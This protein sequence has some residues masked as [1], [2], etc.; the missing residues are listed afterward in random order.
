MLTFR[1]FRLQGWAWFNRCGGGGDDTW[2][3]PG[4]PGYTEIVVD[5]GDGSSDVGDEKFCG[6][7]SASWDSDLWQEM[8]MSLWLRDRCVA[9][10]L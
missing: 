5:P 6:A 7:N 10:N 3:G 2:T 9:I 1:F 4:L 8:E